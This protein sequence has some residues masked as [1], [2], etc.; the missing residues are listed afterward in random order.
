MSGDCDNRKVL[1]NVE[2]TLT[3]RVEIEETRLGVA[4]TKGARLLGSEC[5]YLPSPTV[6]SFFKK[7][8]CFHITVNTYLLIS[9]ARL[10]SIWVERAKQDMLMVAL[11]VIYRSSSGASST[12]EYIGS[13]AMTVG[14]I[15]GLTT[16]ARMKTNQQEFGNTTIA[17]C[18][19]EVLGHFRIEDRTSLQTKV[20]SRPTC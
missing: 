2:T 10:N 4:H 15:Q 13:T 14:S 18:I 20:R 11:T 17:L 6:I 3:G 16:R 8:K 19:P 1:Y 5:I 9:F 7:R 12:A